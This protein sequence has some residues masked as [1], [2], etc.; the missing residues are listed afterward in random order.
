MGRPLAD[1]I[2]RNHHLFVFDQSSEKML[3][4]NDTQFTISDSICSMA[5][6]CEVV[7]TCL[8]SSKEVKNVILGDQG[9][10]ENMANNSL[11][12]DMT[13]GDPE[14]TRYLAREISSLGIKLIDAP[15]SGGPKGARN[16]K[17]SIIVGGNE[18][19]F[20]RAYPILSLIS[21]NVLHAGD[22]GAGHAIKAGNNLLNL[23][24]RMA[25]FEV[26]SM[27]AKEDIPPEN[28]VKILQASSGRNYTTEITL[29]DNILSG[30]MHQGFTTGLMQKDTNIALSLAKSNKLSAPFGQLAIDILQKTIDQY[31]S[32]AD[33][34]NLALIYEELTGVR[35][36]PK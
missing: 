17:L 36:R 13:T 19:L 30:K 16:G 27:L 21:T 28:I 31:G 1:N 4:L 26:V 10:A 20:K 3:N 32:D 9:L 12:I 14:T 25:T 8:P 2:A 15:V 23:I 29:P 35:V 7:L 34:S 5:K 22:I 6:N 11:I 18:E 24:C 33:M